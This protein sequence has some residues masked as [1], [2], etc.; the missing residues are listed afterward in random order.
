MA[1]NAY[2]DFK[3]DVDTRFDA[4]VMDNVASGYGTIYKNFDGLI[5]AF[6]TEVQNLLKIY[7]GPVAEEIRTSC[8]AFVDYYNETNETKFRERA[9]DAVE[10]SNI[11]T[12]FER[13]YKSSAEEI[14][15]SIKSA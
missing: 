5:S 8:A 9:N 11:Q 3:H 7:H 15:D 13:K 14:V 6:M 1:I 2:N 10:T 12:A 4:N